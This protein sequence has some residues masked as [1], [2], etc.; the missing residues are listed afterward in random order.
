MP[1]RSSAAGLCR[2][3]FG[4]GP[5]LLLLA[6]VLL[7]SGPARSAEFSDSA[8]RRIEL[9]SIVRRVM[10]AERNAEVLVLALAPD[11]LA[12]LGRVPSRRALPNASRIPT[13]G[14]GLRTTPAN[15][16]QSARRLH[17]D[18][19]IDAGPV[20]SARAEFADQVQALSGI[21]YIVVDDS[22]E[23]MPQ[24]IRAIGGV[25]G[26]SDRANDLAFFAEH[27]IE[28]LRGRLLIAP[29]DKR[30]HVYFALGR[31]GLETALPG[32]P[33][34]ATTTSISNRPSRSAG[35]RTPRAS[36]G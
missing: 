32:S 22:F 9:P 15:M 16:A 36:T 34:S 31:D 6:A 14:W 20:T 35:S 11:K 12:G 13:I 28:G 25:L 7:S 18:L 1:L 10:P 8:G 3:R 27:A 4:A 5:T 23:R 21:P 30:P 24:T 19:I 33:R 2:K 17:A 29:P 26:V